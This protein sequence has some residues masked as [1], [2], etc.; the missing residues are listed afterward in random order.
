MLCRSCSW[1]GACV[2]SNIEGAR[3]GRRIVRD[4]C[5]LYHKLLAIVPELVSINN[6]M[7]CY[8]GPLRRHIRTIDSGETLRPF[9]N[10]HPSGKPRGY[11]LWGIRGVLEM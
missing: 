4:V 9:L 3:R 10:S 2:F 1:R 6:R 5:G 11:G 8:F 7:K